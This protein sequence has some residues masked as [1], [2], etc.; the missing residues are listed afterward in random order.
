[1]SNLPMSNLPAPDSTIRLYW[2]ICRRISLVWVIVI[3][4]GFIAIHFH[5][6]PDINYLW[7]FLSIFSS[8]YMGFLSMLML[9]HFHQLS[10]I[11]YL[12]LFLSILGLTYMG[13]LSM[14]MLILFR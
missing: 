4:I 5:Q 3:L 12:W 8:T 6:L 10:D 7:L 9:L 11:N 1:M 13:F 2:G 14:L